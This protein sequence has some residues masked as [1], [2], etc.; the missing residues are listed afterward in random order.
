MNCNHYVHGL[1]AFL[2]GMEVWIVER[3][4]DAQAER[5]MIESN[6]TAKLVHPGVK[7]NVHCDR[8]AAKLN[9]NNSE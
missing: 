2:N 3:E 9:R 6:F 5:N 7:L 1:C 4:E 8:H